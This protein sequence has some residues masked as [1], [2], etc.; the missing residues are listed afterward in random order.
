MTEAEIRAK[1]ARLELALARTGDAYLKRV[2]RE[3]I[4]SLQAKL[5]ELSNDR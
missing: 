3:T 1:I 2:T 4:K 5:K